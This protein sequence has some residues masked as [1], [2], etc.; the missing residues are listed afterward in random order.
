MNFLLTGVETNNKGAELMLYAILQ[1]I[2]RKF[3]NSN[4][5]ID[6]KNIRQG[7]EYINTRLHL[8]TLDSMK[9]RVYEAL[10]INSILRRLK[11][12][13]LDTTPDIPKVDYLIDGSGLLFTDTMSDIETEH[14][15]ENVLKPIKNNNSKIIFLPQGFGPMNENHTKRAVA[16]LF[17]YADLVCPREWVSY[18]YLKNSGVA[19]MKKVKT[20]TDF[21]SLVE[22]IFPKQYE[23]LKGAVCVIPN[24]QMVRKGIATMEEY[25]TYLYQ[26]ITEVEKQGKIVYLLNHEGKGDEELLTICK[27]EFHNSI[28]SISGL[29]AL[30]TKGLISTAYLVITSRFHGVASALNSCVPCLATSWSHKYKCLFENYNL[31]DCVLSIKDK[32]DDFAKIQKYLK[33]DINENI[34]KHL[35]LQIPHIKAETRKMW[36]D[37]WNV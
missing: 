14:S 11:L 21:T 33:P 7:T 19:D 10:R 25:I 37:V 32:G 5:Y 18:D 24:M 23:H 8:E 12:P 36:V 4:I 35:V 17:K 9:R 6:K 22:G 31:H 15:W 27:K 30:E 20:Y 16:M 2:E 3:P 29:N 13:I 26:V 34:R 1:E 28:E